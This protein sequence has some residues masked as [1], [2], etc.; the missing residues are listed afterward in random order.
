LRA[1]PGNIALL[2]RLGDLYLRMEDWSRA[3][4]V[5]ETLTGQEGEIAE[6]AAIQLRVARLA[7]QNRV[8]DAL[9]ILETI[10]SD[11]SESAG[12]QLSVIQGRLSAGDQEGAL[13]Y[14]EDLVAQDPGVLLWRFA[15]ATTQSAV[16]QYEEAIENYRMILGRVPQNERAWVDLVRA[17]NAMGNLEGAQAT[18]EQALEAVPGGVNL[19]WA[20]ASFLESTNDVEGAVEI[21]ETLYERLPN[22]P[23]MANNLA[24]LLSTYYDDQE[25]LDRAY[26]I[27]RRLRGV[28]F[29]PFQDTYGWIAYRRGD[30][31]EALEHLEPAAAG[32]QDNALVQ[33]HLGMTY[34]ALE[35]PEDALEQLQ[36]ALSL[37]G[38]DP[39]PQFETARTTIAEI[40]AAAAAPG[41]SD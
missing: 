17:M 7:A 14:A 38:D 37:A 8:D 16:G 10:A 32:L 15:L 9:G 31:Q 30:Y 19:L 21:Y 5:E 24:S 36:L 2:A 39:R 33:Y 28:E 29:P 41:G 22:A 18:L 4:Q 23:I 26:A 27:A 34:L 3:E 25:N 12:A 6:Q 1:D 35:R 13:R 40:E 11:N 20:Q